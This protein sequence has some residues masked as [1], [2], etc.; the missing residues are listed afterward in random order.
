MFH[1]VVGWHGLSPQQE[2]PEMNQARTIRTGL[3]RN[4]GNERRSR[5]AHLLNGFSDA[6]LADDRDMSGTL[7]FIDGIDRAE[8]AGIRSRGDEDVLVLCV[9]EEEIRDQLL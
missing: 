1:I 3:V 4:G 6:V 7:Q 5:L 8:G 2:Q 9:A